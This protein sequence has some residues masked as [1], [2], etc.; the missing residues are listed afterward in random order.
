MRVILRSQVVTDFDARARTWDADAAK[1]ERA[2][3]VAELILRDARLRSDARV[4]E[5]GCGTG[6]LGFALRPHVG[7]ITLA[8]TS[9]EMLAV[10]REKIAAMGAKNATTVELDLTA[11]PLPAARYDLVCTLLTLHHIAD[12]DAILNRFHMLL[13]PGGTVCI[14]DL[15]EEDGS[16]H[17]P[18]AV[19]HNGFDRAELAGRLQRAGFENVR[20]TTCCEVAKGGRQY[21]AFTALADKR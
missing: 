15:D 18:G 1:G 19:A 13:S 4:L 6:L 10:A 7:A 11:G 5:Y 2:R 12:V 8:D 9:R 21:P 20:F 16:F 3:R 17:V 14:A